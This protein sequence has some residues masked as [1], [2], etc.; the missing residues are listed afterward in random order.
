MKSCRPGIVAAPAVDT[1]G[2][3]GVE[4]AWL[5]DFEQARAEATE[6]GRPAKRNRAL[7]ERDAIQGFPTMLLLDSEGGLIGRTGYRPGGP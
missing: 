2:A 3:Q 6:T 1:A 7:A 4:A 5:T